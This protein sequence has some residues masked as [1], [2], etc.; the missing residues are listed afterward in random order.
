[1][2]RLMKTLWIVSGG[3]EAVPGIMTARK[4]GL[5]V[6]VS[7]LNPHA[8]GFAVA[9]DRIVVSTYDSEATKEAAR[10]Y[11]RTVRP[12]D[13]VI[14]IA[15]DVP[16]T[17]ASV[18]DS[19]GLPG[20][21]LETARL[22]MDKLA[23]K[24]RFV[25]S[26]IPVPWFSPVESPAHLQDLLND[27]GFPL[28]LKPVDS[29][30][31]RGVLKLSPDI[32]LVWAYHHA[33]NF[34]P[35]GRI[36]AEEYLEGPQI[37]TESVLLE[38]GAYT[39]GFT[40]R[41]YEYL[42]RFAPYM[43]ENGGQQPSALPPAQQK[44]VAR[45]AEDA[46]RSL[47]IQTGIAKGDMILTEAG[48]KVIEIAARL[49]GGWFSTDQ[50]PLATGVDIV[51]AA[52]RLALGEKVTKEDLIPRCR[53]GVAIRYFFPEPGRVVEIRN[54]DRFANTPWVHRL[55]FFVKP[56]DLIEPVSNH[57]QRAGFVITQ[58]PTR[59]EAVDRAMEVTRTVRITTA[60]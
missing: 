28:V 22:A 56:G 29:R 20:I 19:L 53:K 55:G 3:S 50:I 38:E 31:A 23:M 21:S 54:H 7:D 36:M 60:E 13:G 18:A 48:P 6:V 32:D 26:H 51:G 2:K 5:H 15:S 46:G 33:L 8:P 17:V 52:I 24:Q 49:S 27:C 1:M 41:N 35:S 37:S 4:M 44:A 43:I 47:G 9:D 25:E 42:D 59:D 16:L 39:P 10:K 14:C 58:G 40:D 34:S 30:G 45:L 12:I 11:H 57:T